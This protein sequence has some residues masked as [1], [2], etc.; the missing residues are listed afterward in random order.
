[1]I[2]IY[3]NADFDGICSGAIIK[4]KHQEAEMIGIDYGDELQIPDAE[5]VIMAD[6][7]LDMQ[8]MI[9]IALAS[10][11]FIWIDHHISKI[12][13]YNRYKNT[14]KTDKLGHFTTVLE[15]G[16]SACELTWKHLF[17]EK[18]IPLA[19]QL[20]G[21]YDTWRK[22]DGH[23]WETEILPFQFGMRTLCNNLETFNSEIFENDDFCADIIELG[24]MIIRYQKK[25]NEYISRGAFEREFLGF[26]AICL[27]APG[28]NSY[29][30]KSV[31]D[32]SKHDLMVFFHFTGKNWKI[33]LRTT[34]DHI[35]CSHI[36]QQNGGGGHRKASG[37]TTDYLHKFI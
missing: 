8:K 3:H 12:H 25:Q 6:V 30:L 16:I 13:E 18:Q 11:T 35:D 34:K 27:N 5:N 7:S 21:K 22:N 36:A 9:D 2:G 14:Y 31:Y 19:V 20:L 23:D 32:E 15:D 28:A 29:V 17:P 33:S 24:K 37:F 4:L 10:E 1:M 26:K